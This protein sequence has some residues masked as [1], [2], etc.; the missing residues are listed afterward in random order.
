MNT[1]PKKSRKTKAMRQNESKDIMDN[2]MLDRKSSL[3]N[4]QK[5]KIKILDYVYG[6]SDLGSPREDFDQSFTTD[7]FADRRRI[8]DARNPY[9]SK[10]QRTSVTSNYEEE[11]SQLMKLMKQRLSIKPSQ[12]RNFTMIERN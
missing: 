2:S 5:T 8:F 6:D 9:V 12:N 7:E 1:S 4:S 11:D 3:K 10:Q